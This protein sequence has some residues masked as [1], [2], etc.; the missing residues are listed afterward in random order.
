MKKPGEGTYVNKYGATTK[1]T[2]GYI[3]DIDCT[4]LSEDKT[5]TFSDMTLVKCT[6]DGGDGRAHV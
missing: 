1:R 2:G 3:Q 4:V 6:A 5:A